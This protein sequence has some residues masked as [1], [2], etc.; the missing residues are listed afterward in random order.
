MQ[1]V[2]LGLLKSMDI[3]SVKLNPSQLAVYYA[4]YR[5]LLKIATRDATSASSEQNPLTKYVTGGM[6]ALGAW[7]MLRVVRNR[8]RRGGLDV[9]RVERYGLERRPLQAPMIHA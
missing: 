6:M 2:P 3:S 7:G 4:S 5:H 9:D 1:N 8:C